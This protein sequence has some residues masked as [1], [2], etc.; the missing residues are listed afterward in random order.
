MLSRS[1]EGRPLVDEDAVDDEYY[2]EQMRVLNR[3]LALYRIKAHKEKYQDMDDKSVLDPCD[4]EANEYYKHYELSF[5]WYFDPVYCQYLDLQDYQRLMLWN[6]GEY[7]DWEYYRKTC[8]TLEGDQ[9]FVQFWEKLTSKT[10]LIEW[11]RTSRTEEPRIGSL[12]YYNALKIAAGH[13]H[14]CRTL[15]DS[16]FIEFSHSLWIDFTWSQ[17]YVDFLFEMWKLLTGDKPSFKDAL[18]HVYNEDKYSFIFTRKANFELNLRPLEET[19]K[20]LLDRLVEKDIEAD[21]KDCIMDFVRRNAGKPKTYYDYAKKK[22]GIPE[23]IGLTRSPPTEAP[24]D[25]AVHGHIVKQGIGST[26]E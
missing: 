18:R 21:V 11:Y 15:I 1:V 13:P 22:L 6:N 24:R 3:R 25:K 2:E 5:E 4:F 17:R 14:V 26:E 10:K 7:D 9:G 12:F 23:K 19:Y 8:N 16:G 20:P